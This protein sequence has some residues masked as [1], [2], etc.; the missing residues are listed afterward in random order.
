MLQKQNKLDTDGAVDIKTVEAIN[1]KLGGVKRVLRGNL[2]QADGKPLARAKVRAFDKD[3]RTETKLG[4]ATSD[5]AGFFEIRYVFSA[6]DKVA[7]NLVVKGFATARDSKTVAVSP[8]IL[9]ADPQVIINLVTGEAEYRGPSEF[10][11]LMKDLQPAVDRQHIKV[12]DLVEDEKTQDVTFLSS[13]TRHTADRVVHA[14]L[15]HRHGEESGLEPEAFYAFLRQGL[16]TEPSA[17]LSQ[18]SSIVR[19]ALVQA[20]KGNVIPQ[21]FETEAKLKATL[22]GLKA[23]RVSVALEDSHDPKQMTLGKLVKDVL[24]DKAKQKRFM[25]A[26]A[27]HWG[28]VAEFWKKVERDAQLAPRAAELKFAVLLGNL[29]QN[30]LP[31]VDAV[32]RTPGLQDLKD[33]PSLN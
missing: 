18:D 24:T 32:R 33:L 14:V 16:P 3:L 31:L 10:E 25:R 29:G 20:V 12:A 8:V 21:G 9:D 22:E 4:E 28:P 1:K 5:A 7:P 27:E 2:R 11:R 23:W 26:Y 19:R 13:Q 17:L 15:S 6:P 30:Y